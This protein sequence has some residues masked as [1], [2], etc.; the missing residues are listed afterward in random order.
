MYARSL[1]YNRNNVL[2]VYRGGTHGIYNMEKCKH[3]TEYFTRNKKSTQT[4]THN[5][6]FM[7]V[8]PRLVSV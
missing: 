6:Y 7:Q 2:I 1:K 4:L 3:F 8:I 5:R